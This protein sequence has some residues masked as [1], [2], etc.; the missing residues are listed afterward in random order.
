MITVLICDDSAIIRMGLRMV[1]ESEPDLAVVGEAADGAEAVAGV[2]EVKPDIVLLDIQMPSMNGIEATRRILSGDTG[3]RVLVLTTYDHDENVYAALGAGA[4]GFLVKDAPPE[5]VIEAIKAIAAGD[6][7]LS[8]SV[9]RRLLDSVSLP[10]TVQLPDLSEQ[11]TLLL[12]LVAQGRTN[13]EI[14]TDLDLR[15]ATVKTYVS[16]LFARIGARD[17]TQAVVLAYES[18]LIR[19]GNWT[20]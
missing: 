14:A 11:D 17:R 5:K 13:N 4:S 3:T 6:A 2:L 9:T 18:G 1:V 12:K 16:R 20:S 15:P 10:G 8:P 19:P 7:A